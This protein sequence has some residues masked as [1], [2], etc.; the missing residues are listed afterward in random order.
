MTRGHRGSLLLRCRAFPSPPS[1][2]FIPALSDNRISRMA[3]SSGSWGLKQSPFSQVGGHPPHIATPNHTIS[4][5]ASRLRPT[6]RVCNSL[7]QPDRQ[8][9]P[10]RN[11]RDAVAEM[12]PDLGAVILDRAA[13]PLVEPEIR[14]VHPELTS[15]E[16]DAVVRHLRTSAR[17]LAVAAVVLQQHR[18]TQR[19]SAPLTGE[20]RSI[21]IQQGPE[22]DHLVN[23]K[24]GRLHAPQS[25]L[26]A[27]A[28]FRAGG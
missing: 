2:R 28:D 22:L 4:R 23:I 19:S 1:C 16:D 20:Q 27:N 21:F 8:P 17:E 26:R 12:V 5:G 3:F 6:L 15:D 11:G 13:R 10:I 25:F 9:L 18:E 7:R 24:R 14:G